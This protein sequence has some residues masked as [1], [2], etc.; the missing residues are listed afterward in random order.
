VPR[1]ISAGLLLSYRCTAECRYCM[2][3]CSPKWSGWI[4]E[5][6]LEVTLSKLAG[7]IVPSPFGPNRVSLN[8]GL[9]FT[10]GEPFLNFPL[11]LKAVELARELGIPSTFVETNCYWCTGDEV[12]REKLLL[13]KEKGLAGILISVNP[14]YLEYVPFERT[15]RG[16]RLAREVFGP[17]LMV[18][19][20]EYYAL[21]RQLGIRG[22]LSY[23]E[24]LRLPAGRNLRVEMFLMGR[25]AYK[26]G[27]F[28]PKY[29]AAYFLEQPCIP[30]PLRDWHNHFDNYGNFL[31]GYCGGL[32]LGDVHQL[33]EL[34]EEGLELEERPVLKFLAE[35][36]FRGLLHFAREFGYREL[37]EGYI[38]KCHLCV[39]IRRFLASRLDLRELR[40]REF[41]SF[42]E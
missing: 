37:R 18:Y 21:F 1:P 24:Y 30:P 6:L 27:D 26:L 5:D 32:S 31:P 38:S 14:F 10:G 8:Y 15:E 4:S 16:I 41:Y 28:Y 22:R 9:H 39:D 7:K 3:A 25:A 2:Y 11:L 36:D 33:E 35:Q 20:A 12:T 17:N 40:P 23:E 29:P 34:V 42:L 19:Q 13:L